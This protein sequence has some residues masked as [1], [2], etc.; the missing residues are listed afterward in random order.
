MTPKEIEL[1]KKLVTDFGLFAK[2]VLI[3]PHK[4]GAESPF[5]MNKAQLYLHS[6]VEKQLQE[7]GYI[8]VLILKGRQQG[9]STYVA[10]RF[11][12]RVTQSIG[13]RA[14]VIAH[15]SETS[16]I[17]FGMTKNYHENCM[18]ALRPVTGSESSKKYTFPEIK[19]EYRVSTA[20]SGQA[21]RGGTLQYFHGSEVAF[22][23]KAEEIFAGAIESVPDGK[24][25]DGTE[26][27]LE[28]T[29]AGPGGKFYDLWK[30]AEAGK[31]LY[32]PVFIPW[33]WQEEYALEIPDD[34]SVTFDD[35]ELA[36]Q[37]ETGIT[38]EQ[39]L[40]RRKKIG[41]IGDKKFKREY[42]KDVDEAF[43][44][45]EDGTFLEREKVVAACKSKAFPPVSIG[46][47]IGSFDPSGG[48]DDGD[49]AGLAWGD[50]VAIR[51]ITYLNG[52]DTYQQEQAVDKYIEDNDLDWMWIDTTGIG[53]PIYNSLLRGRNG[54]KVKAFVAAGSASDMINEKPIYQNQRSQAAGRFRQ[55]LGDGVL[56]QMPNTTQVINEICAPL[57]ILNESSGKIQVESKKDMR[58]RG[59]KSPT[60]FDLC[61]M[62][63]AEKLPQNK[64][65]TFRAEYGKVKSNYN[66]LDYGLNT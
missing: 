63:R 34:G 12:W 18:D 20:N 50:D 48:G 28:S 35:D 59:V 9:F 27:F 43:E 6:I 55:W 65:L 39:L 13:K 17:L 36:Y 52:L 64:N 21:G 5:I 2:H 44:Y 56:V 25:I 24:Y 47:K 32:I 7:K 16:D 29:S 46:A 61:S 11:Y 40:W 41:T 62:I 19:G 31:N 45:S 33:W 66:V 49:E 51:D 22:W 4:N 15:T 53:L 1:R 54:K 3:I 14:R 42:P 26:I 38:T 23:E 57:E 37:E 58:K 10:G 60:A 8:R 30:E